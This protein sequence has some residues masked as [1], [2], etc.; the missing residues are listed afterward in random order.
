LRRADRLFR[1][2]QLLR[3]RRRPVTAAQLAERLEVAER[4]VYRDVRDLI[5]S[6]VPIRGEAGVGYALDRSF[7]LPPVMFQA[8][9]IEALVLGMRVVHGW[10]D[11]ELIQAATRVLEKLR[12]VSPPH[13]AGHFAD[14]RL[15]ALNFNRSREDRRRL[16]TLRRALRAERKVRLRYATGDGRESERVVWPIGLAFIAPLWLVT[17]WC[18]LRA[19]FRNFRLDRIRELEVLEETFDPRGRTIEDYLESIGVEP[20]RRAL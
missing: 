17:T 11:E 10:A 15:A 13:L 6:G 16:S 18:E 4:T 8:D 1:L 20:P 9:E 7:D 3:R 19:A 5:A 14:L 12:A 2:V